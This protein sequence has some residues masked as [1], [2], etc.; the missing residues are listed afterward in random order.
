MK[1]ACSL[2]TLFLVL[3]LVAVGLGGYLYDRNPVD[4]AVL[5][6]GESPDYETA[7]CYHNAIED[8]PAP[9]KKYL[10]YAVLDGR[11]EI[12]G[13]GMTLA[14]RYRTGENSPWQPLEAEQRCTTSEPGLIW[15]GRMKASPLVWS[16]SRNINFSKAGGMLSKAAAVVPASRTQTG[17]TE[18]S[19]LARYLCEAVWYPTVL[20][21][22]GMVEWAPIDERS[23]EAA[24]RSGGLEARAV[25]H[26]NDIG[27]V[28]RV[29]TLDRS[30]ESGGGYCAT[31]WT[32]EMKDYIE[33]DGVRIPSRTSAVWHLAA[34]DLHYLDLQVV[35]VDYQP[36]AY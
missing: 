35:G 33:I 26:F 17:E 1:H 14:G 15:Q 10:R 30:R 3:G 9:V 28:V 5:P 27:Q 6:H 25:F 21:A 34:G 31:K 7:R 23:A 2:L 19:L 24:I 16:S 4:R 18:R 20:L 13:V 8:L 12:A 22:G 32:G 36:Q 29:E 11:L